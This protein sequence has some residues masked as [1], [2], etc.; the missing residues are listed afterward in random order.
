MKNWLLYHNTHADSKDVYKYP[1][2]VIIIIIL[3][4]PSRLENM[5]NIIGH[6]WKKYFYFAGK[7]YKFRFWTERG[8]Y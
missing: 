8:I 6:D 7:N 4:S 5:T 1:Q 3:S 2:D